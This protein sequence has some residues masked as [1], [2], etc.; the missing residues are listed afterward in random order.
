MPWFNTTAIGKFI[1]KRM[2]SYGRS[3]INYINI[4]YIYNYQMTTKKLT[5]SS[6]Y[7]P[8]KLGRILYDS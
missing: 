2:N 7:V 4:K 8:R 6:A 5:A 1:L 3:L